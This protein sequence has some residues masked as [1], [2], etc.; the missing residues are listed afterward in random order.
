MV[1]G[2]LFA[3][4]TGM[5]LFSSGCCRQKNQCGPFGQTARIPAPGTYQLS[6]PSLAGNQPYYTPAQNQLGSTTGAA[7]G[8]ASNP[9][10]NP[11]AAAPTINVANQNLNGWAQSPHH[12]TTA[13]NAP[14]YQSPYGSVANP[15]AGTGYRVS[16]STAV[17]GSTS[18]QPNAGGNVTA[19]N[20]V[21]IDSTRLAATDATHVRGPVTGP[22]GFAGTSEPVRY[23]GTFNQPQADPRLANAA[24]GVPGTYQSPYVRHTGT[25]STT[26]QAYNPYPGSGSQVGWVPR[27]NNGASR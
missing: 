20:D 6:I 25:W 17:Q 4:L 22:T 18:G 8:I 14:V 3:G 23:N 7:T 12:L 13:S 19:Q 2:V 16:S 11:N 5:L 26:P 1:R 15:A 9:M 27:E 10:V 21:R 24:N